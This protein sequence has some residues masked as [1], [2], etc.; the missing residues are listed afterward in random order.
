MTITN[1]R[2]ISASPYKT[3]KQIANE[4]DLS[5]DTIKTRMHEMEK[6]EERYGRMAV[7]R[8]GGIVLINYLAFLDYIS[9]RTLLTNKNTRKH[10]PPYDPSQ[11]AR[12]IGWYAD[13]NE[14]GC[15]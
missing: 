9:N 12:D 13:L 7:I 10:V 1:L 6:E 4:F 2:T 11:I 5:P 3:K 15:M 8:D 14:E